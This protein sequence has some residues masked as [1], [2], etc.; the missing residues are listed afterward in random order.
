MTIQREGDHFVVHSKTGKSLGTIQKVG[1]QYVVRS[2]TGKNLG[3]LPTRKGAEK[4]LVEVEFFK[5]Q[6]RLPRKQRRGLLNG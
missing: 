6:A 3:T 2:A 4:K 1:N 5:R